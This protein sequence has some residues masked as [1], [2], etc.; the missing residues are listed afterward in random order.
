MSEAKTV[1]NVQRFFRMTFDEIPAHR[2]E[3]P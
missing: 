3:N 1:T 2:S